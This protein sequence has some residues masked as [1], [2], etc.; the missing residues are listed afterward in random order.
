MKNTNATAVRE[1]CR[2]LTLQINSQLKRAGVINSNAT[3]IV[4]PLDTMPDS[5]WKTW[6]KE[7]I[8]IRDSLSLQL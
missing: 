1:Q 7:L 3:K 4:R 2:A 5:E 6:I 8:Q